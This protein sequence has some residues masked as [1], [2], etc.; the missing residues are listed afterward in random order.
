[1]SYNDPNIW[2][3]SNSN[4]M[5]VYSVYDF[6]NLKYWNEIMNTKRNITD[7][8]KNNNKNNTFLGLPP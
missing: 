4:I 2:L 7:P 3:M 5:I 6:S 8:N 1:M